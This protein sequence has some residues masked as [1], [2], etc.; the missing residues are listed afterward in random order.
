MFRIISMRTTR[1][2]LLLGAVALG[3]SACQ[4]GDSAADAGG[5]ANAGRAA[6]GS[7]YRGV[8][9]PEPRDKPS[10]TLTATDGKPYDFQKETAGKLTLLFFGYTNCPDVCPVHM[11]NIAAVL[12]K[13]S[14]EDQ[15]R[16]AVVFV[17]TDPDRDTPEKIRKWLDAFDSRF[18][19]LY[20]SEED[21]NRVMYDM[22]LPPSMKDAP[23]EDGSY[24]VGHAA[25][26]YAFTAD[27]KARV[28]YPFG[29]RQSDWAHD[30]PKLLRER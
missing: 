30:L 18:V 27:G 16:I 20:G 28:V 17:T 5:T 21:V 24:G 26:V 2:V 12:Q 13:M 25:Q 29:T 7:E 11:A 19:G 10:F 8:T 9:L 22:K 6:S 14:Y 3:A 15:Q 1:L 4:P 23:A